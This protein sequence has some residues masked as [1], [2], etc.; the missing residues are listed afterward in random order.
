MTNSIQLAEDVETY[1]RKSTDWEVISPATLAVVNFRYNPLNEEFT[2]KQIDEMNQYISNRIMAE[3]E[4][5]LVTTILNKQVV[6][7]MCLINPRTTFED[8]SETLTLCE[9]FGSEFVEKLKK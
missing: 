9:K 2:G 1:L 7:R 8:V 5:V 3:K 4:A 6:L